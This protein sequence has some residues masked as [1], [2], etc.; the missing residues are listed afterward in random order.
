MNKIA[1]RKF[2]DPHRKLNLHSGIFLAEQVKYIVCTAV[3]NIAGRRT[4][5]L[6]VYSKEKSSAGELSPQW[7]M[8]QT[9]DEYSTLLSD[10]KGTRWQTS[11]F[12]NL[13]RGYQFTSECAFY[14]LADEQ[15][16]SRFCKIP[17]QKGFDALSALQCRL[18]YKRQAE[19]RRK[20]DL[21]IIDRMKAVGA[22]PRDM[23]GFMHRET[24]P[25]YIF[26]DYRRGK[27]AVN[28]YCTACKHEVETKGAKHNTKGVCPLCGKPVTFKSRGK[29]GNIIDRSTAQVIERTGENELVVRFVKAYCRYPKQDTPELSVYENAR[30]F[31]RW[32]GNKIVKT[33]PYYWSYTRDG[34]TPWHKGER[35][36]FSRWQYNF[37]ADG[38]GYLYHRNLDDALKNTPFRYSALKEY[39]F[40]DPTPLYVAKYLRDYL[41]Y[42]MLEYLVKLRLYRLATYVVY[43]ENGRQFYGNQVLNSSGK[44]VTEV[45]GVNKRHL[46]LLQE[47]NPGGQ[48]L[49]LM[50]DLL[51]E[52]IQP[53]KE[54]LKWCSEYGVGDKEN[55][56]IPLRFM[57]PHRFM[58]YATEQFE[59]HRKVSY[60]SSGYYSM[61]YLLS[62]YAD[63]LSMSEALDYDMKNSFVLFPK[64]LKEAHDR[65]NDLSDEECSVAYDRKIAKAFAGLQNRYRF[66]GLGLVVVPPHSA[67]EI[68]AEGQKLHH[69][70]GRYVKDVVQEKCMILF[71]RKADAPNEPFC[72]VELKNEDIFQ[73]RINNNGSPPPGVQRFIEL[74]KRQVLCAPAGIAA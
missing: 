35:P 10:E 49:K 69:C 16:V 14:S 71:I 48:Q 56:I 37:E 12:E 61:S 65:V 17:D 32:D 42:P 59:T 67:K 62:D 72:T 39:Y 41:S 22:L 15:R 2:F 74:W 9:T 11:M 38:C 54:L 27:A 1:L 52:N 4:L 44:T 3:H 33:E 20:K 43:G 34:L 26:Y 53:D 24:M 58:R 55:I 46:P 21:K 70:V 5:V 66:E 60:S 40:G 23:K 73:A 68:I 30:L 7:T 31:L 36:V 63:Y 18:F 64:E 51:R 45:L 47:V 50:K 29:R 25:Q 19:N 6:Y 8:F 28:G 13:G 57:T